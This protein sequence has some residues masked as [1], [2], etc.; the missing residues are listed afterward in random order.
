M[1]RAGDVAALVQSAVQQYGRRDCAFNNAGVSSGVRVP[2][3]EYIEDV[4]DRVIEVN[5]K[6]VWLCMKYEIQQMLRQG[7]G[8]IVNTASATGLVGLRGS[9][10]YDT[11]KHAVIGL[12]KTAAL[13]YAQQDIRVN[14]VC[15]GYIH[16]AMTERGLSDPERA[17]QMIALQ[18]IGRVGTPEEVAETVVWLCSE[19]ASFV[20]GHA[21]AVDGGCVAQ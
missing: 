19:A 16:T 20:T 14:A 7:N 5:L 13:E 2:T 17:E 4:W 18:P 11:S 3:H 6:G 12:T 10:A 9:S 15:P 21:M 8:A 1:S